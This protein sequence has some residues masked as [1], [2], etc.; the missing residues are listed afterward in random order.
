MASWPASLPNPSGYTLKPQV[1]FI[2]TAM[3]KGPSRQRRITST[4]PTA[5]PVT[6]NMTHSEFS[7]FEY[8]YDV[9]LLNGNEWFTINLYNGQGYTSYSA[10]FTDAF[11]AEYNGFDDWRIQG[12]LEVLNRPVAP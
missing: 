1:A 12:E 10:R 5:I 6:W 8:F 7:T 2:R 11:V 3:E 9:T 4:P